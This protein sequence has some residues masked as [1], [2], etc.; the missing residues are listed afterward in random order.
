MTP[1]KMAEEVH[2]HSAVELER[3]AQCAL[4]TMSINNFEADLKQI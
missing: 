3:H 2:E 1:V 4:R